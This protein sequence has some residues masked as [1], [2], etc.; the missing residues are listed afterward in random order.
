[1]NNKNTKQGMNDW[2]STWLVAEVQRQLFT[3]EAKEFARRLRIDAEAER[4]R[5]DAEAQ[6]DVEL[7][8]AAID[9]SAAHRFKNGGGR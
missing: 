5:I 7:I 8:R 6:R 3:E 1:M 4:D 2:L 9:K